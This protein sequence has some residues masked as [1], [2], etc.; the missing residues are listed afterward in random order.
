MSFLTPY[1]REVKMILQK[2]WIS[3]T[4]SKVFW[5]SWVYV[6]FTAVTWS[7][8]TTLI[9]QLPYSRIFSHERLTWSCLLQYLKRETTA[10]FTH[11]LSSQSVF[12]LLYGKQRREIDRRAC[13]VPVMTTTR[14]P[15]GTSDWWSCHP[16]KWVTLGDHQAFR[17]T[18][19]FAFCVSEPSTQEIHAAICLPRPRPFSYTTIL[20]YSLPLFSSHHTDKCC[21]CVA[22]QSRRI[23]CDPMDSS[24]P[25]FLC[26][27]D[28]PGKNTWVCCHALFQGIFLTQGS[29]R[30]FCIAS[31]FFTAEPPREVEHSNSVSYFIRNFLFL[32]YSRN[33]F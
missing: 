18:C 6:K 10:V 17:Q 14:F 22:A 32:V 16:L 8:R 19:K 15:V 3:F 12:P 33:K 5:S 23:L 28:S 13:Q 25:G 2:P 9:K 7:G 27:W 29:N 31:R 24:L 21:C 4:G 1:E 26:P 20:D 11:A 30:V